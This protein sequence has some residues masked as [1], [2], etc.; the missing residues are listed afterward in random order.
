MHGIDRGSVCQACVTESM[1]EQP[2]WNK[3]AEW[4]KDSKYSRSTEGNPECIIEREGRKYSI[5]LVNA[6]D[7][8][9]LEE[10]QELMV[11]T[12]GEEEVDPIEIAQAGGTRPASR[13][14]P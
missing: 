3:I 1:A 12:F 7:I 8:K 6:E 10:I 2:V 13:R 5:T 11:E 14:E 9:T 4:K